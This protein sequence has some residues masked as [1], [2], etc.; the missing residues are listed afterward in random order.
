M[1][2]LLPWIFAFG[3]ALAFCWLAGYALRHTV[4][5]KKA[6]F[7]ERIDKEHADRFAASQPGKQGGKVT[8]YTREPDHEPRGTGA[9]DRPRGDKHGR[10]YRPKTEKER[11][12]AIADL[13]NLK[14][15]NYEIGSLE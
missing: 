15:G 14:D 4:D 1:M 8:V 10:L 6:A 9:T 5:A 3:V 12:M 7:Y 13:W 11:A 2:R